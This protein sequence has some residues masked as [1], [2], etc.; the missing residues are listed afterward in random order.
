[1]LVSGE[2]T[3]AVAEKSRSAVAAVWGAKRMEE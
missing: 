1:M 2:R 3:R